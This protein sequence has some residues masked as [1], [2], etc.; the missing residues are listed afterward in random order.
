MEVT[1]G[2]SNG[3]LCAVLG[4]EYSHTDQVV[5]ASNSSACE[6]V[7]DR[8]E[9]LNQ[10]LRLDVH[11]QWE[12]D[13]CSLHLP[14]LSDIELL[15]FEERQELGEKFNTLREKF[16]FSTGSLHPD[17]ASLDTTTWLADLG[18]PF[19]I[20]NMDRT[21]QS[22]RSLEEVTAT[23]SSWQVPLV[24]DVQHA[25]EIS[26]DG[27]G[28]GIELSVELARAAYERSGITHLHVSGEISSG[29]GTQLDNHASLVWATNTKTII[30][31]VREIVRLNDKPVKVILEGNYLP[32][33]SPGMPVERLSNAEQI[34]DL[35]ELA[36]HNMARERDILMEGLHR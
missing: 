25:F 7:I 13:F 33:H 5:R 3:W 6:L 4:S 32:P 12:L 28:N 27:G 8:D 26:V 17:L 15:P 36:A 24:L 23:L 21:K 18:L 22:H 29:D 31:A 1:I 16:K 20:E 10:L 11:P 2:H 14:D 35:I 34:P 19:G 9:R 30:E